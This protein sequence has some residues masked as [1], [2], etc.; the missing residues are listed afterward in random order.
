MA[1]P[2]IFYVFHIRTQCVCTVCM[3]RYR[4]SG[5]VGV[6]EIFEERIFLVGWIK[7]YPN[8]TRIAEEIC[9][10]NGLLSASFNLLQL[11][12]LGLRHVRV[13]AI[14]GDLPRT[15][16]LLFKDRQ[17]FE[18]ELLCFASCLGYQRLYAD[19]ACK[20]QIA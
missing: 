6:G 15:I 1:S 4:Y 17:V 14:A 8:Q 16:G 5:C 18:I 19:T 11:F 20:S 9:S 10:E 2:P 7:L 13:E 12:W 3:G